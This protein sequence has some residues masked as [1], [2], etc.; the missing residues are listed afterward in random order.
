MKTPL[1]KIMREESRAGIDLAIGEAL[2]RV[3]LA[4][5][6]VRVVQRKKDGVVVDS[7]VVNPDALQR[8]RRAYMS[9]AEIV[10]KAR[11]LDGTTTG[12]QKPDRITVRTACEQLD[13]YVR[14]LVELESTR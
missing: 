3:R 8:A 14:E 1:R 11:Q 13:G 6:E 9:A 10:G 5:G 4:L 12:P 7:R 2:R